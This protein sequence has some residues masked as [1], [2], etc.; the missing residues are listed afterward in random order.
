MKISLPQNRWYGKD[1]VWIDIPDSW[2]THIAEMAGDQLPVL[3]YEQIRQKINAPIGCPA[4]SELAVGKRSAVI[5]FDDMSRG[6]PCQEAAHIIL[7]ELL[8]AGIPKNKITFLC[9]QGMH[10]ALEYDDFAKKLG[11]DIVREYPVFNHNPYENLVHVGTTSRGFDVEI[12]AEFMKYD[13]RIGIGGLVPHPTAGFGGG[14]KIVLPGV[15]GLDTVD[16]NHKAVFGYVFLNKSAPFTNMIG[17]LQNKDLRED[18]EE[19]A[20][21]AGLDFKVDILMNTNCDIVDVFS[22]HPIKEYYEGVKKAF[23]VYA[24]DHF[25]KVDV[26][27]AN[28]NAKGNEAGMAATVAAEA[29]VPGGDIV[30]INFCRTGPVAHYLVSGWGMT[31]GGRQYGGHKIGQPLPNGARRMIIYNPWGTFEDA[32][33]FGT[34]GENVFLASTWEEVM[35]L[36][37]DHGP[38]TK[39]AVIKEAL[40]SMYSDPF[41]MDY[42][43]VNLNLEKQN[44]VI[45]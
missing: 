12:N 18:V 8:N 38:G 21:L 34:L 29:V 30:L 2:E 1:P 39:C 45:E 15:T 6:T 33:S 22:G 27:I 25:D 20:M 43:P 17:N 7:E 16:L 41:K 4:L 13:L 28:G 24:M 19:V 42:T 5:L 9:A 31:I 23:E 37:G 44:L 26:C 11:Q 35:S 10:G 3:S 40:M 32:M 36:L 14:G